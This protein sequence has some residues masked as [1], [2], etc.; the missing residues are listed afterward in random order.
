LFRQRFRTVYDSEGYRKT[1]WYPSVPEQLQRLNSQGIS[2]GIVTNKPT[3]PCQE[4]LSQARLIS[5]FDCVI[6]ID[7]PSRWSPGERFGSKREALSFAKNNFS[8]NT[9][10]LPIYVGDTVSDQE[11]A[12]QNNLTFLAISYGYHRWTE[13]EL[14]PGVKLLRSPFHLFEGIVDAMANAV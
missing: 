4:L 9:S 1:N 8:N 2:L 7:Y 3:A 12:I 14:A 6:G 5:L 11:A 13:G 10:T